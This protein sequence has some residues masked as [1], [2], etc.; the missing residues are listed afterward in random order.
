[1]DENNNGK[2]LGRGWA[3]ALLFLGA[4]VGAFIAA[5]F[6]TLQNTVLSF[7][8]LLTDG[9]WRRELNEQ[10]SELL[11]VMAENGEVISPSMLLDALSALY[12][13]VIQLLIALIAVLGVVGFLYIRAVSRNAAESMAEAEV[14][15][16]ADDDKVQSTVEE[17]VERSLEELKDNFN[18]QIKE[19]KNQV[20]SVSKTL[21]LLDNPDDDAL[22]DE[23]LE[24]DGD[25]ERENGE[26]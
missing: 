26:D 16:L 5:M 18:E 1:M 11:K 13:N 2:P 20:T 14:K 9:S 19:L 22:P 8:A 10:E 21:S 7:R 3:G 15:K 24:L 6:V 12:G 25:N 4:L 23:N 17:M